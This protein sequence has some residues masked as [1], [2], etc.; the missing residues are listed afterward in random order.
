M[1]EPTTERPGI[2]PAMQAL[3]DTFPFKFTSDDDVEV[4][5]EQMRQM[6]TPP[7]ALPDMRIEERTIDYGD[8]TGI[9][10]RIYWPPVAQHDNLPVVVFYHGGGWSIGD[11]DTHDPVARTHALGAEAIVVS[12]D[13]RL[14]PEHPFPAAVEDG[15][16]AYRELLEP[17]IDARDI[18]IGGDSAGGGLTLATLLA[19][20]DAGLPQPAAAVVFSPWV[21]LTVSGAS[22]QSKGGI[23]PIFIEADLRAYAELYI[24]AGDRAQPL[25]SPLF[26]DLTGLPPLLIQVGAN[27]LLL[28]DAVRLAGRA[29]ADDV[30]VTL[31]IGSGLPHVFQHHYGRL[32]EADDALDRAAR[33]MTARVVSRG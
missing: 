7:E 10:V 20:R 27:E 24:G 30:E 13:Y 32:D 12:V 11:L 25:A 31:E 1:A 9:P 23:D 26:A 33:F 4:A 18:V 21:D 2:D 22:A 8:I 19:A 16:A 5:R 17:G 6:K 14:A 29:G 28:D 3:L 15:L